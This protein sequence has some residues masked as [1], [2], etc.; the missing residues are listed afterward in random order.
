LKSETKRAVFMQDLN[1]IVEQTPMTIVAAIIHKARLVERY[2]APANP[3]EIALLFCMERLY[4][5]LQGQGTTGPTTHVLVECRGKKEDAELELEFRRIRDGAN[6]RMRAMSCIE[7]VFID[8]KANSTG[9]QLAD[10]TA[11]PIGL[12]CL[13]PDQPN[14][15][16]DIIEPK[17]RRSPRGRIEGWGF[18]TFP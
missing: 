11:R 7:L 2:R 18:K 6:L 5:F 9:L 14:R 13:R 17:L 15:A 4:A 10:L 12:R 3:Y 1:R 16:Y 8:K